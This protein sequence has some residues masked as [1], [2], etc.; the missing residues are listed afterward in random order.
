MAFLFKQTF[1]P[2]D[3]QDGRMGQNDVLL[4]IKFNFIPT[5]VEINCQVTFMGL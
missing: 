4:S 2:D 1:I 3:H 5:F